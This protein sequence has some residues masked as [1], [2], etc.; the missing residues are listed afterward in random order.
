MRIPV[1]PMTALLFISAC[2][3]GVRVDGTGITPACI[4]A[5][6]ALAICPASDMAKITKR[7][8]IPY[9]HTDYDWSRGHVQLHAAR[10]E[11]IAFQ[12]LL[13]KTSAN[14]IGN[15]S[16]T[17]NDFTIN[18]ESGNSPVL[19]ASQSVYTAHYH[20]IDNGGY[21]WGPRTPVL[22]W[23]AEYPDALISSQSACGPKTNQRTFQLVVPQTAGTNQSIWIDTYIPKTSQIGTYSQT[24]LLTIDGT[25]VELPIMI[26]VYPATL[27]DKPTINAVGE[28]YRSYSQEGAGADIT[29]QAW[30]Q[31]SQCYQKL[32]HQHRMVFIER[33]P[34]L[35]TDEQLDSYANTIG[36]AMTGDL[37][38][39]SSGYVGPG[40]NTP[41]SIWKTPWPQ[42]INADTTTGISQL[43]ITRFE[44]LASQWDELVITSQWPDKD[45]FAYV[46]DEVDGPSNIGDG[47]E[48]RDDYI[49]RIHTQMADVQAA[50][51]AGTDTVSIDLLWTSHSNPTVWLDKP[52]QDLTGIIRLWAPNASAADT[53]FLQER[54]QL[55]EKAWFYH[56]GHPAVGAHSINSSG[57]EM[58]TW[59][60]IGARYGFQGQFM[61]AVNLGNDEL[62]FIDPQYDPD[63]DRAGNGVMVYPGN[64]LDKIG[65][66][67]SPGPLPS[68][69]LKAWRRGLQDAEIYYLARE[70]SPQ[71][72]K[73]QIDRQIPSALSEG[74]G[75]ASW[76]SNSGHWIDFHKALLEIELANEKLANEKP[77][78]F[79][80]T[81]QNQSS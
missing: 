30:Q 38:D 75:A 68:M 63:E 76:S 23:P 5:N 47:T 72:A 70:Q 77:V 56:S 71:A 18:G 79:N 13:R 7:G 24:L 15:V 33:L 26:K 21:T 12:L 40:A 59:G 65:Y 29:S 3:P 25:A 61:W 46:F 14:P 31:M 10:N 48:S 37:F 44:R 6:S 4:K 51:D 60:V 62:P 64:Q 32:A 67:K 55:G 66:E 81:I 27:P 50:I 17:L 78:R 49:A 41:V 2:E 22:P 9:E 11:T 19:S 8:A 73:D 52:L 57:I 36:P 35:L 58:R 1:F 74:R 53:T 80:L 43:E 54:I 28:I 45:Y 42:T 39:P 34:E 16:L 20:L 69:R